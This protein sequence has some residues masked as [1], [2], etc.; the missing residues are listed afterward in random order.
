MSS[1]LGCVFPATFDASTVVGVVGIG[2]EAD[3]EAVNVVDVALITCGAA[4]DCDDEEDFDGAVLGVRAFVSGTETLGTTIGSCAGGGTCRLTVGG[5]GF[6]VEVDTVVDLADDGDSLVSIRVGIVL[7]VSVAD[8]L[9]LLDSLEAITD[10]LAAAAV[11]GNIVLTDFADLLLLR[12]TYSSSNFCILSIGVFCGCL[13]AL[14]MHTN[15]ETCQRHN[16]D[17]H[18][19]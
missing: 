10:A 12:A 3:G 16:R 2:L 4:G 15:T 7:T 19:F 14:R 6:G 5:A 8:F 11:D 9:F 17:T 13:F 1:T 18:I